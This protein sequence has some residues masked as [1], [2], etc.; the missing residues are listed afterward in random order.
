MA[1][2]GACWDNAM[3]ESFFATLKTD[4]YHRRV[5]PIRKQAKLE[6]GAWIEDRYNRRRRHASLGEVS[7]VNFAAILTSD[8][9]ASR[10]RI[11]LCP[12]TG[13]RPLSKASRVPSAM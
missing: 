4:F 3:A 9:G 11:I 7:P 6:V 5:W 13:A 2:T 8:R 10:S 12:P 1:Y